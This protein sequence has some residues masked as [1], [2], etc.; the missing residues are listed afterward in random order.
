MY[1]VYLLRSKINSEKTYIGFASDLNQRFES[2]NSGNSL[3]TAEFRPWQLVTYVC[4]DD[5]WKAVAFEKYLKVGS[6]HAFA[7]RHFW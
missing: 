6:G 7:R 1:Y 5:K 2:H 4:F 3:H